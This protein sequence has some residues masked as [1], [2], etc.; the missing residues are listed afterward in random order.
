MQDAQQMLAPGA[1]VRERYLVKSLIG[2]GN[3]GVVY[4]VE[5]QRASQSGQQ[6]FALKEI[7]GLN[8]QERMQMT[9]NSIAL[10]QIDHPTLPHVHHVFN[11]DRRNRVCIIIQYIDGPDLDTMRQ[12]QAGRRFSWPEVKEMLDP[13]ADALSYLHRQT[14]PIIHGDVKPVNILLAQPDE[15]FMLVD[16]GVTRG[17]QSSSIHH[18]TGYKAPEQYGKSVDERADIYGLGATCYTLLTGIVPPNALERGAHLERGQADPLKPVDALAP[19]VPSHVARAIHRSLSIYASER[20]ASVENFWQALQTASREVES[21]VSDAALPATVNTPI[22]AG[23]AP[24]TLTGLL[25]RNRSYRHITAPIAFLKRFMVPLALLAV[26]VL[27]SASVGI[28]ALTQSHH[29]PASGVAPATT[30][31]VEPATPDPVGT[32]PLATPTSS[33]GTYPSLVGSY[34]GTIADITVTSNGAPMILQ[35]IHQVGG[36]IGGY[37]NAGPPISISGPFTGTIDH[38]K[39]FHF[40]V[41]DAV[42]HPLLFIEGAIQSATY[43]SGD[44]YRCVAGAASGA[45]CA[46]APKGSGLWTAELV[47]AGV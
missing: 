11:D 14:P 5:D 20:F 29:A 44:F 31:S 35:G 26:I 45:P 17:S 33:P 21:R 23:Y 46:R 10:R 40:I 37:F 42:G 47:K 13:I 12:H 4:L 39:N 3:S 43:L 2:R 9:F 34:A 36:T 38:A 32:R 28:W 41:R 19:A 25:S 24:D 7:S 27:V 6:L 30:A 16:I 8:K 1:L 18:F 15:R 22:P